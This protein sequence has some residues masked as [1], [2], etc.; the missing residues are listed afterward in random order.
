[1]FADNEQ[2]K[3]LGNV[4][5]LLELKSQSKKLLDTKSVHKM[6]TIHLYNQQ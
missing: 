3:I 6:K 2:Q 5:K 1:M 4:Q